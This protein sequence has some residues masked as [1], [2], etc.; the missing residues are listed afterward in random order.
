MTPATTETRYRVASIHTYG[1][2]EYPD[3]PDWR[4]GAETKR[5][6]IVRV[7]WTCPEC[8]A[9]FVTRNLSHSCI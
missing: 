6:K 1:P 8:G 4:G 2:L 5:R 3:V 9:K 7:M